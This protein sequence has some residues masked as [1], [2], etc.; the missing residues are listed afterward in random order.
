MKSL[1]LYYL[2]IVL[3]VLTS[4]EK[5]VDTLSYDISG[6]AQKGP[7][8]IGA[9]ITV[10]ELN[11]NLNQTGQSFLTTIFSDDGSFELDNIELTSNLVLVSANGYYFGELFGTLSPA[12]LTLQSI[13]DLSEKK[14]INVNVLTHIIKDRIEFLVSNSYSYKDAKEK[15]ES[16][17]L[18][19]L[20]ASEMINYDFELL[21]IS[22][23][24]EQN[25]LLLAF[26]VIVQRYVDGI[27]ERLQLTAEIT[28]LLAYLR[29][30]FKEDGQINNQSLVDT[31]LYNIS[32]LNLTDIRNNVEERYSELEAG[33]I[34]PDFEKYI[35]KFQVKHKDTIY[36]TY[37][38]PEEALPD[39]SVHGSDIELPNILAS[40]GPEVHAGQYSV[41]AITPFNSSLTIKFISDYENSS[42]GT[43]GRHGWIYN[44]EYPDGFTLTSQRQNELMSMELSLSR[45]GSAVIEI[46][47]DGSEHPTIVKEINW[48][49]IAVP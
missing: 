41:A 3:G 13:S 10:N 26:S 44:S 24:E 46:Y 7:F 18:I 37:Y 27:Y 15:A 14:T 2:I 36:S 32:Q 47:E 40:D 20:G 38:Y 9:N 22:G 11:S 28:Q 25:A 39:L 49:E 19:F 48:N 33:V 17:L 6:K 43:G 45:S 29:N 12:P 16:E 4:C 8:V 5:S 30:D 35:G 42:Y 31:L 23:E 1:F 21:D 34:I